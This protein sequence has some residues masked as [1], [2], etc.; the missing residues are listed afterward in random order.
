MF[1]IPAGFVIFEYNKKKSDLINIAGKWFFFWA[2]GI[3]LLVTGLMQVFNPAYTGGIVGDDQSYLIIQELGFANLLMGS[4]AILSLYKPAYIEVASMGGIYMGLAGILHVLRVHTEV[5]QKETI[6]L[7]S[8]LYIFVI[9]V[10]YL[11][12]RLFNR[13]K[14]VV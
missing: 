11:L 12:Y 14:P 4:L 8:D 13:N 5:S 7:I 9:A 3:R 6:A 2:I 1:V 10:L